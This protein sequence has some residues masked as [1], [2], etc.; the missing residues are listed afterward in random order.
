MVGTTAYDVSPTEDRNYQ[1][2]REKFVCFTSEI[3]YYEKF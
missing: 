1:Y 3:I 2:D